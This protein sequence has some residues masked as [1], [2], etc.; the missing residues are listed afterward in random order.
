MTLRERTIHE[1]T[2]LFTQHGVKAVRMDDIASQLGISKRTLYELFNDKESLIMEC[3]AYYNRHLE[4]K[5]DRVLEGSGNVIEE[6]LMLLDGGD[7]EIEANHT[8]V[9]SIKR[10]YP[11][12]F[13][14]LEDIY[15]QMG[16]DYFKKRLKQGVEDGYLLKDLDYELAMAVFSHSMYGIMSKQ[17]TIIPQSVSEIDAFRYVIIY[18]FRGIATNKGIKLIDKYIATKRAEIESLEELKKKLKTNR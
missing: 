15:S 1:A 14:K 9:M 8:L 5:R 7:P 10:F 11:K 4:K 18:F 17:N 6:F 3:V 2:M 16:Y 13:E 12:I